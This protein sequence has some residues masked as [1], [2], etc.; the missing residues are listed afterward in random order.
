MQTSV[1]CM[2]VTHSTEHAHPPPQPPQPPHPYFLL[3][4]ISGTVSPA[5]ALNV[6][7]KVLNHPT[8][9][10]LLRKL[11]CVLLCYCMSYCAISYW[12]IYWV[13]C[14]LFLCTCVM[15]YLTFS[16][17]V[18]KY[19]HDALHHS[20]WAFSKGNWL[21]GDAAITGKTFRRHSDS[22]LAHTLI[23]SFVVNNM[24]TVFLWC[25]TMF[26]RLPVHVI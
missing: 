4:Y 19:R 17:T 9:T 6:N 5:F 3:H 24:F 26:P 7:C 8:W 11:G 2:K 16:Q 25:N 14:S 18:T 1:F 15:Q 23:S 13:I 10:Q 21:N 22:R 12:V 20:V